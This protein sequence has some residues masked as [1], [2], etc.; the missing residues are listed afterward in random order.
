MQQV[1][2]LTFD[3]DFAGSIAWL[4]RPDIQIDVMA[5]RQENLSRARL[6]YGRDWT[7][8]GKGPWRLAVR[9]FPDRASLFD[10]WFMALL[11]QR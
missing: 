1:V 11:L 8:R 3:C 6:G 10:F 4:S 2:S 9:H 7:E 5:A